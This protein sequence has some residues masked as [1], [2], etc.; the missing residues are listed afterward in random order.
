MTAPGQFSIPDADVPAGPA[1]DLAVRVTGVTVGYGDVVALE[2]VALDIRRGSLLAVFGLTGFQPG[3]EASTLT[4]DGNVLV[5]SG[6]TLLLG[7]LPTSFP[8][9]DDPSTGPDG[10]PTLSSAGTR[11]RR[12]STVSAKSRRCRRC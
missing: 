12:S 1:T 4:V 6:A 3:S 9:F 11:G 8:C 5:Q 10:S 2:G 7:C